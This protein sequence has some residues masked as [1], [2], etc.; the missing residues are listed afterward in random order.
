MTVG[1]GWA[2]LTRVALR[3]RPLR[4]GCVAGLR[5]ATPRLDDR[6]GAI[7]LFTAAFATSDG[8]SDPRDPRA[9]R[10]GHQR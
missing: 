8:G 6:V 9:R 10:G 7:A 2:A 1:V 3:S 5:G 4:G